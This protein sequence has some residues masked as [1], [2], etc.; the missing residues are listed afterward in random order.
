MCNRAGTHTTVSS[1]LLSDF[2]EFHLAD[3]NTG[4]DATSTTEDNE[5]DIVQITPIAASEESA[6]PVLDYK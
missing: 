2:D 3:E 5:E 1:Y 6:L 4:T